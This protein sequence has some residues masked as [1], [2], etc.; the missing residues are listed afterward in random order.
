MAAALVRHAIADLHAR[1]FVPLQTHPPREGIVLFISGFSDYVQ[2]GASDCILSILGRHLT[3]HEDIGVLQDDIASQF[4]DWQ[5]SL[6]QTYVAL[7]CKPK[8][9]DREAQQLFASL[10]GALLTAKMHNKPESF[11]RAV[12]RIQKDFSRAYDA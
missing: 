6:V 4:N 7:G 12:K 11:E 8:R 2:D 9:A 10:Y 1:A 3:A 5:Q